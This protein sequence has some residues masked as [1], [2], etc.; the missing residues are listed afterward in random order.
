MS[1]E[2]KNQRD[3]AWHRIA[4]SHG[5]MSEYLE[6]DPFTVGGG[7]TPEHTLN[8][9]VVHLGIDTFIKVGMFELPEGQELYVLA[10]SVADHEGNEN[11]DYIL[12]VYVEGDGVLYSTNQRD[13]QRGTMGLP[14]AHIPAPAA[15]GCLVSVRLLNETAIERHLTGFVTFRIV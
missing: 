15:P 11:E 7:G 2:Q 6:S 13:V 9:P 10:A 14:L 8:C 12:Q 4:I 1:D 5:D 3:G